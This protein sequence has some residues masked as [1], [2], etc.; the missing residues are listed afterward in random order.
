MPDRV[1]NWKADA[2]SCTFTVDGFGDTGL[3]IIEKEPFKL[4]KITGQG[5]Q[6]LSFFLWVQLKQV[7]EDDTRVR[8]TIHSEMNPMMSVLA[9]N[10][11]QKLLDMLVDR[12][13][14]YSF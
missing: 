14:E 8:L 3:R 5:S 6:K 7:R 10:P 9:K 13:E 4:I 11:L 2:D 12:M 1:K